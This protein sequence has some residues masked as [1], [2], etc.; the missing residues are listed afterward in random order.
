MTKA[1]PA[2]KNLRTKLT[3][4]VEKHS[5]RIRIG[6]ESLLL[7]KINKGTL[8]TLNMLYIS[9]VITLTSTTKKLSFGALEKTYKKREEC[10]EAVKYKLWLMKVKKNV[11]VKRLERLTEAMLHFER[12]Y[13]EGDL[14]LCG[15]SFKKRYQDAVKLVKRE[16][17]KFKKNLTNYETQLETFC[18]IQRII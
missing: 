9:M 18:T 3:S 11:S 7:K 15:I 8:K 10:L 17:K 1:N 6:S 14:D 4:M 2:I 12:K 13:N 5:N 16:E